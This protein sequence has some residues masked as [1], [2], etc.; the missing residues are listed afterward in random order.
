[1]PESDASMLEMLQLVAPGTVLREGIERIIK[2]GKGAIIVLGYDKQ[3]EEMRSGGFQLKAKV[4]AQQLSEVAKM[5]GAILLDD[6]CENILFAN[7]HLVPDSSVE[8]EETGTRHRTADRVAKQTGTPVI[9]VSESMQIVSLY[10]GQD[11]HVLEDLAQIMFRANQALATLERYRNRLD[12]VSAALS[13]LEIENVVTLGNVV[14]VLQRAERVARIAAEI[15]HAI[16]ELGTEGR[17]LELQLDELLHGVARERELVVKDYIADRRRKDS[18]VLERIAELDDADLLVPGNVASAL[19]YSPAEQGDERPVAARGYRL[20]SRI[21]RLP[22]TIVDKL[23]DK[24]GSLDRL[25]DATID[26]LG[27]IDGIGEAR[28]RSIKEG[29]ARLAES[30]ILERYA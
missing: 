17:L 2:A 13:A 23:V 12:E 30:S 22:S 20:L 10:F 3:M 24:F 4:T 18:K 8:T 27:T 26:D 29:L 6:A 28:A 11:K 7:V 9:S 21:P 16:T 5:D 1:M 15:D 19:G 14:A 25:L